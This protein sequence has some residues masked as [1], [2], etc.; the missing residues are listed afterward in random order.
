ML[1]SRVDWILVIHRPVIG[2]VF[3]TL[4]SIMTLCYR[5]PE[6]LFLSVAVVINEPDLMDLHYCS[7]YR[8][9]DVTCNGR[10]MQWRRVRQSNGNLHSSVNPRVVGFRLCTRREKSRYTKVAICQ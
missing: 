10:D 8:K 7:C 2:V 5:D 3:F 1:A 6:D 4:L 9:Q